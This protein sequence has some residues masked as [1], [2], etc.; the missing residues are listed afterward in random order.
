MWQKLE[1]GTFYEGIQ[2]KY[3]EGIKIEFNTSGGA[4]Y[5]TFNNP[6]PEEIDDIRNGDI[7]VGVNQFKNIIFFMWKF[8]E[9]QWMDAPYHIALSPRFDIYKPQS[10]EGYNFTIIL[11]NAANGIVEVLRQI[12]LPTQ[13]SL[14]FYN[15]LDNQIKE[16]DVFDI[17]KYDI[18]LQKIYNTYSTKEMLKYTKTYNLH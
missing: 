5:I 13:V 11:I 1:V 8:G 9:Q 2:K 3:Q 18:E 10:G 6:E 12:G 16:L 17:N 4:I 7:K 14:E 15:L